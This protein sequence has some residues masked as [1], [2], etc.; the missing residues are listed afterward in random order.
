MTS[1]GE[2]GGALPTFTQDSMNFNPQEKVALRNAV[3]RGIRH[4]AL[5]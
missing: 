5:M 4:R 2:L 1:T 3:V